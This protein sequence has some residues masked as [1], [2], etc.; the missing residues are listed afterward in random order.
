MYLELLLLSL[1]L[2]LAYAY[3]KL[4]R[5]LAS[6]SILF[7][8]GML[9]ATLV[10]YIY[11]SEWKLGLHLN[12]F[13]I[14]F[15]GCFAFLVTE[16]K[17]RKK[18]PLLKPLIAHRKTQLPP[19]S[20]LKLIFFICLQLFAYYMMSQNTIAQASAIMSLMDSIAD[21]NE[22]AKFE[23]EILTIPASI[24]YPYFIAQNSM[25]VWCCLIP[26]YIYNKTGHKL[27]KC[28]LVI[29]YLL[30]LAGSLFSGGRMIVLNGI[31]GLGVF[32]YIFDKIKNG[33]SPKMLSMKS[34]MLVT[35]IMA[36]FL[37]SFYSFGKLIG[38]TSEND[39][40][41]PAVYCGAQ[42]KNLDIFLQDPWNVNYMGVP[43]ELSLYR[44]Y[45]DIYTWFGIKEKPVSNNDIIPFQFV[46]NYPLGNVYTAFQSYYM[47]FG[48]FAFIACII[49]SFLLVLILRKAM[50]TSFWYTGRLNVWVLLYSMLVF[51][52][53]LSFFSEMF[54]ARM[55]IKSIIA[56]IIYWTIITYYLQNKFLLKNE[57]K[58]KNSYRLS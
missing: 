28:L 42:I 2:L 33:W 36:I 25:P 10:A 6:P 13:F 3:K 56:C 54:F 5:N 21:L 58:R 41:I 14:I 53:F 49:M 40:A 43:L 44:Q 12:T 17:Y 52:P 39:Y 26:F 47:D 45:H 51:S 27:T 30:A 34:I 24:R 8:S 20:N 35:I 57:N 9:A 4:E 50:Q 11:K 31:I 1:L 16:I 19:I 38:R 48:N 29:N 15:S 7:I 37:G 46:G 23:D 22:R 18:H 55:S 32:W